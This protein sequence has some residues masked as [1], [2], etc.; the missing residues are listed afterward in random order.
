MWS[1]K[2]FPNPGAA[3]TSATRSAVAGAGCGVCAKAVLMVPA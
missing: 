1:V 3:S 2:N